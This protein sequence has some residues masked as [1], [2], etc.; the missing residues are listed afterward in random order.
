KGIERLAD[1]PGTHELRRKI[2]RHRMAGI[3]R[4]EL[5]RGREQR[6]VDEPERSRAMDIAA[7]IAVPALRKHAHTGTRPAIR[8][9]RFGADRQRFKIGVEP[10]GVPEVPANPA[11][12]ERHRAEMFAALRFLDTVVHTCRSASSFLISAIARAGLS[13]LGQAL[14]QFMIVWQR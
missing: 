11:V 4:P 7:E 14:A 1:P 8:G 6:N 13:P 5:V 12:V 3:E 10:R 9:R 2:E